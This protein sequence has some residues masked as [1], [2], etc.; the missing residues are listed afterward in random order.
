M[1]ASQGY[2]PC[3]VFVQ[4]ERTHELWEKF[5]SGTTPCRI[6]PHD[7]P[8]QNRQETVVKHGAEQ[9]QIWRRSFDIPPPALEKASACLLMGKSLVSLWFLSL[10]AKLRKGTL[11]DWVAMRGLVF[12]C[13]FVDPISTEDAQ[14]SKY[15]PCHEAKSLGCKTRWCS[16]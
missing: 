5:P 11:R 9:V 7:P 1:T 16:V 6:R 12:Q 13:F 15:H 2:V 14:D 4:K 3:L 10:K 8:N